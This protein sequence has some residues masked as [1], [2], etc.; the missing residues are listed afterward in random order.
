MKTKSRQWKIFWNIK[1][2]ELQWCHSYKQHSAT[3]L[4]NHPDKNNFVKN[5]TQQYT[6]ILSQNR[7][8]WATMP[9][10]FE[11]LPS[12][13][14]K[15]R[16][17]THLSTDPIMHLDF[18][19]SDDATKSSAQSVHHTI[20]C[21]RNSGCFD[22]VTSNT[23]SR[24][25]TFWYQSV[26]CSSGWREYVWEPWNSR[27]HMHLHLVNNSLQVSQPNR[28]CGMTILQMVQILTLQRTLAKL[29]RQ[30]ESCLDLANL[31]ILTKWTVILRRMSCWWSSC[32]M[33]VSPCFV[34]DVICTAATVAHLSLL[35][36]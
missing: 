10:A 30:M 2:Q 33:L 31:Q 35:F 19:L 17:K 32:K 25:L 23:H 6:L 21:L 29:Q 12:S 3:I 13:E 26:G 27:I 7:A 11:S 1:F 18:I 4:L 16:K 8:T 36:F 5:R 22:R 9:W 14:P 15:K 34:I 20:L 28:R 24:W